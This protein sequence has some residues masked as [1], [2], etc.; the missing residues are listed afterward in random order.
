MKNIVLTGFMGTGK[1]TVGALLAKKLGRKFIDSDEAI[2]ER[3]GR[4][5]PEIFAADGEE[6]FRRIEADVIRGLSEL[7][8]CII[9]TGGGVVLNPE[10]IKALRKNGVVINLSASA[11]TIYKRTSK[12]NTRPLI[13]KKSLSEIE[14]LLSS[15]AAAYANND[16]CI[17]VDE[18][19]PMSSAEKIIEIYKKLV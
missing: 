10:N 1:S 7:S 2:V 11:E 6:Y 12:S 15:R 17:S 13:N 18:L 8:G 9:A 3:E 16:F 4:N 14:A 5:I 19:T